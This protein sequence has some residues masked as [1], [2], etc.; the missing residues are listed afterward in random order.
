M[1][2]EAAP[3]S[4]PPT[5]SI[6]LLSDIFKTDREPNNPPK[7]RVFETGGVSAEL[8]KH[9]SSEEPISSKKKINLWF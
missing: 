4:L 1:L 9:I 2:T 5:D 3:C 8:T 6:K 7:Q